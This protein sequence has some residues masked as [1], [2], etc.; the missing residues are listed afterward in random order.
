MGRL[1]QLFI[2]P[3]PEGASLPIPPSAWHSGRV[4][5]LPMEHWDAILDFAEQRS[6]DKTQ[7]LRMYSYPKD[8]KI[9]PSPDELDAMLGFIQ[10]VQEALRNAQALVPEATEVYPEAFPNDE[11]IRMLDAVAA[12][13]S[14]ARRLGE[15]FEGDADT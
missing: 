8:G 11:H 13:L 15:P 9:L 6:A 3:G 10:E 14:E 5:R 7:T 1:G 4:V 12:V 2:A